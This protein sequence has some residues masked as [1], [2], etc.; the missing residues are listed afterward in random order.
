[1]TFSEITVGQ[2]VEFEDMVT[3]NFLFIYG[4]FSYLLHV[5]LLH[6]SYL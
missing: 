3:V 1:V 6:F 4:T 5:V 2:K